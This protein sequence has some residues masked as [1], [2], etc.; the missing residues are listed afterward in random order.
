M[1]ARPP[2][3]LPCLQLPHAAHRVSA[4]AGLAPGLWPGARADGQLGAK[5]TDNTTEGFGLGP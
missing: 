3:P 1:K 2:D 5:A 4:L